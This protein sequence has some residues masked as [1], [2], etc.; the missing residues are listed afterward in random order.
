[1]GAPV[2][3][4][5]TLNADQLVNRVRVWNRGDGCCGERL[6]NFSITLEDAS[7]NVI[8]TL[9]YVG[10]VPGGMNFAEFDFADMSKN[11]TLHNND[12]VSIE[13]SA[14]SNS[15]D[16]LRLGDDGLGVLTID[17]GAILNV[18]N[19]AGS[20]TPGQSF[21][22]LD[23]GTVS[24]TFSLLN[25]PGG[26]GNWDTSKLYTTGEITV[27]PEPAAATLLLAGALL[28]LRRRRANA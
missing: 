19:L 27:V 13:L 23:F 12:L 7:H 17:S 5:L 8:E 24:G 25:L 11:L 18:A 21:D 4:L 16:E 3:G 10:A 22:I 1:M 26:E 15:G 14:L 20:F 6:G 9:S 2:E 28:A